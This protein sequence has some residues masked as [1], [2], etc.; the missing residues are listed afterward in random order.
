M[1]W[2]CFNRELTLITRIQKRGEKIKRGVWL[3]VAWCW[4]LV[5]QPNSRG[6]REYLDKLG[7]GDNANNAKTKTAIVTEE[8]QRFFKKL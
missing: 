7:T 5:K 2:V 6:N 3:L 8:T 4:L 1:Y